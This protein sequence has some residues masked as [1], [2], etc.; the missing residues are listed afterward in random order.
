[1]PDRPPVAPLKAFI[2]DLGGVV[3]PIDYA[4]TIRAFAALGISGADKLYD[5]SAQDPLFDELE[6]GHITPAEFR[7]RF[8]VLVDKPELTDASLDRAWCALLGEWPMERLSFLRDLKRRYPLFL[9]SN[10][11]GLHK[12][13]LFAQFPVFNL[14]RDGVFSYSAKASKPGPEIFQIAIE[15]LDLDPAQTF[16]IDD[17]LP[18]IE[19]A[20]RLGFI[21]HHYDLTQHHLLESSLSNW[22]NQLS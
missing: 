3:L 10:T 8:R 18:N 1:M 4:R 13:F 15:Q 11:N 17:L 5:K 14:F 22:T 7:D 21:T 16:Y 19:T 20:A 9:L 2:F 12:D 6:L